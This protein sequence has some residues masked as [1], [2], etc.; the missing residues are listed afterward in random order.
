MLEQVSHMNDIIRAYFEMGS[1]FVSSLLFT[2]FA[3]YSEA[4]F[5]DTKSVTGRTIVLELCVIVVFAALTF[6]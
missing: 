5:A 3:K 6:Q 4:F 1:D 2:V